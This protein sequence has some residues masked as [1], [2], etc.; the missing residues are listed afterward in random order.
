MMRLKLV[1]ANRASF[2]GAPKICRFEDEI[3]VDDDLGQHLLEQRAKS[4]SMGERPIWQL[5]KETD[6][7]S[8]AVLDEAEEEELV[9]DASGDDED[10]NEGIDLEDEE[11]ETPPPPAPKRKAAPKKKAAARAP[12]ARKPAAK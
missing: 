7:D 11:E 12:R 4:K 2:K 3:D 1:G 9:A 8:A 6:G 10:P 5:V